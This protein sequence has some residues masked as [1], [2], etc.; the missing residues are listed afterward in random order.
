MRVAAVAIVQ[1]VV[2]AT[3]TRF[4]N[5]IAATGRDALIGVE[6]DIATLSD[7][8][9]TGIV[10]CADVAGRIAE[11]ARA[12]R[13]ERAGL[14]QLELTHR[15]AT[16]VSDHIAVVASFARFQHEVATSRVH[17]NVRIRHGIA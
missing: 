17:A 5:A 6:C 3:F 12:G 1:V 7:R 14:S 15:I 4:D 10:A 9:I 16:V 11:V 2:V 8:T 13:S